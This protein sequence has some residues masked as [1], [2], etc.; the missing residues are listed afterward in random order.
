MKYMPSNHEYYSESYKKLRISKTLNFFSV[1]RQSCYLV[2]ADELYAEVTNDPGAKAPAQGLFIGCF[3]D[4]AT[5]IIS[6]TC[7]GKETRQR[8][9]M[10][11]GTK[12][13]PAIFVKATGTPRFKNS[14]LE[15]GCFKTRHF[16]KASFPML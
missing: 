6:F 11:P 9:R 1:D 8:F 3:V 15:M 14:Y 5:G 7:E 2:R 16:E 12:L 10:E 4:S 13:F